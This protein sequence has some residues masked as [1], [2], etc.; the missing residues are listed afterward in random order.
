MPEKE[1]S[2]TA[3]SYRVVWDKIERAYWV[4]LRGSQQSTDFDQSIAVLG[5]DNTLSQNQSAAQDQNEG[6]TD[7][8]VKLLPQDLHDCSR[9]NRSNKMNGVPLNRASIHDAE[10]IEHAANTDLQFSKETLVNLGDHLVGAGNV[11]LENKQD[12]DNHPF[13]SSLANKIASVNVQSLPD[14]YAGADDLQCHRTNVDLKDQSF[15]RPL[16]IL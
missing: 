4:L 7:S 5:D 16:Q 9:K 13:S 6:A 8:E 14:S 15:R 3:F 2:Y 12:S 10:D 11:Q 1:P